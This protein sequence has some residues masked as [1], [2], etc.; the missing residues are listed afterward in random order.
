MAKR[1]MGTH[2]DQLLG[3]QSPW[4]VHEVDLALE[5]GE[6]RIHVEVS[7]RPRL[8]CPSCGQVCPGYDTRERRWRHLDTMQYRTIVI[9]RVPRVECPEHGVV[10]IFVSWAEENSRFT[11]LFEALVI[12]W[13]LEASF[14][15]V[16]RQ[17][18]LSWDQVAGI[19]DRAVRRGLARRDR[20]APKRIGVDETS[21]QK[22]HEYVTTV[23]DLDQSVVL[24]VGEDRKQTTLDAYFEPLGEP[25]CAGLEAV[26]MDRWS[27]YIASTREHVPDADRKIVFDKFHVAKHLGDAVDRVRRQENKA[28][29]AEGD[30]RLVRTKYQWLQNPDRMS[31]K[32]WQAFAPLRDSVLKVA[33][34]WAI[35]ESAMGLWG[36]V[37]RGWATRMWTRWYSW[38]IRSRLEP[39]KRV[40]RMIKRHWEGVINAA[41]TDV[42]NARSEGMNSKIQWIKRQACGFRNRAR[43]RNAIYFH[44]GGLDL[45]PDTLQSTHSKA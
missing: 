16:A 17:L 23:N 36:Y 14:A 37:S 27:P 35:K 13:L 21:F 15:A 30:D 11:A 38:A 19:Q 45:Y 40:A 34:A 22:R 7:G 31:R 43:F 39:I 12:D 29:R 25:G 5:E 41:T 20:E 42:T 10:Q 26:A 33:R 32:Q 28:L 18:Q 2:Y 8:R 6:V 9:G 3:L 1:P 4:R 24:F 44:L